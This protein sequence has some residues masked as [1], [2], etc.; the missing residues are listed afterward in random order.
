MLENFKKYDLIIT[1]KHIKE[2]ILKKSSEEKEL[3]KTK[4]MTLEELKTFLFQ[5]Y[6]EKSIY[7]LMKKHNLKYSIAK[8]Y[9]DNIYIDEPHIKIYKKELK[10]ENLLIYKPFNYKNIAFIGYDYIE[11]YIKEN[12]K[13]IKVNYINQK[14]ETNKHEV[15]EFATS[16]EELVYA[17]EKIIEDL[18]KIDIKDMYLVLPTE[19]YKIEI[20]R[21]FKLYNIPLNKNNTQSIYSTITGQNFIKELKQN[22]NIEQALEKTPKNEIY[23]QII[24][25][26]NKY[27]FI[28]E[29][30]STYIEIIETELKQ[31]KIKTKEIKGALKVINIDEIYDKNKYY[32]ILG[33]NQNI[34]PK[35]YEESGLITDKIKEKNKMFTSTM[36]NKIEKEKIKQILNYPNIYISY[37]LKDNF[38]SYY[39]SSLIEDLNLEVKKEKPKLINSNKYNKLYL[40]ALIDDYINYNEEN[41]DINYLYKTYEDINY[42]TYDNKY[43]IKDRKIIKDYLN[44]DLTLSYTSINNYFLCPF[45]FYIENILKLNKIDN[46]FPILIGNLFHS[47]LQNLYNKDFNLDTLFTDYLKDKELT[48]KELFFINKLKEIINKDIEVIKMQDNNTKFKTKETEKRITLQKTKNIKFTGIVDKISTLDNYVIITDYKTGTPNT[49]L[50]NIE[51]GLNMQLPVYIYLIKNGLEKEKQIVGFYLQKLI[52]KSYTEEEN[53]NNLKLNGYTINDENIIEK[54]DNTYEDSKII[55]GMKKTKN[56]FYSYTKLITQ[57]QIEKI[58]EITE[59]N[60]D[61]VIKAIEEE[62]FKIN[63]KR[64]NNEIISCKYCK[65]KDLCFYKEEDITNLKQKPFEEIGDEDA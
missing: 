63:P 18:K 5:S 43:K 57:K 40:S 23:N 27:I 12:L 58:N 55:K 22:K 16:E 30:D 50:D 54:I 19:D 52:N 38:N 36:Q 2:E 53:I 21:I 29:I 34:M 49:T 56:G 59:K 48:A 61:K 14:I 41:E 51:D 10:E 11:P 9:L 62:N 8:H 25:I 28:K 1:Q 13:N 3:I 4:F 60:I 20:N 39:P 46:T 6:D 31:T 65:Y 64:L 7:Y 42:K 35:I 37:K 24:N 33:F 47:I 45:K 32:Y 17:C 15:Y 26:L 44:K